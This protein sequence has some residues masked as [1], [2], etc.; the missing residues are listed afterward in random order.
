MIL[1]MSF[2]SV[3]RGNMVELNVFLPALSVVANCKSAAF[4]EYPAFPINR[5]SSNN[6]W[7]TN[8]K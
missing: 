5:N 1:L 3:V 7:F 8:S 4:W 2:F 6:L